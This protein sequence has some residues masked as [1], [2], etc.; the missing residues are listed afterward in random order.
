[1]K[2]WGWWLLVFTLIWGTIGLPVRADQGG[3]TVFGQSFLL[4]SGDRLREDLLVFGGEVVL[5][6]DSRVDGDV[7]VMGGS[8]RIDARVDGSV[9]VLGGTVNL[10]PDAVVDGDLVAMGEIVTD[11]DAVVHGDVIQGVEAS[12]RFGNVARL[13]VSATPVPEDRQ[14]EGGEQSL[15]NWVLALLRGF[16]TLVGLLGLA[17]LVILILPDSLYHIETVMTSAPV[18]SVALGLISIV[19]VAL[20]APL[21]TIICIGLPLALIMVLLLVLCTIVGLVAA[22]HLAGRGLFHVLKVGNPQAVVEV[23]VGAFALWLLSRIPCVGW[24]FVVGAASWGIG[25]VI[26]TRVGTS[27]DLIWGPFVNFSG[28][29]GQEPRPER[30]RRKTK[31]L[32]EGLFDLD[33]EQ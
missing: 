29:A 15:G 31:P 10:G 4:E 28:K 22:A 32:D 11:P 12:K 1:M 14:D 18:L 7:V 8:A 13:S 21:L 23:L 17:V 30:G 16:L 2:R 6:P 9:I 25:A 5:Q 26:L 33:E 20:L 3:R 19:A 27:P 24:L